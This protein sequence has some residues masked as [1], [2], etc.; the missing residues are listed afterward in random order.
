[1]TAS[2]RIFQIYYNE[3]TKAAID[4]AFEPLDNSRNERPDW[5]EY[6]PIRSYLDQHAL[7]DDTY[8]GFFSPKF[9]SKTA[10]S[11][12]DVKTFVANAGGA[13][14]VT[15]S[16]FPEQACFYRNVFEQGEIAHPGLLDAATAFFAASGISL[17][18]RQLVMDTRNTVYANYF[19]AKGTFWRRWNDLFR[20]CFEYSE[21]AASPLHDRLCR[22]TSHDKPSQMKIFLMERIP[23][24]LLA[25]MSD[26]QVRNCAPFRMPLSDAKWQPAFGNLLAMDGLKMAYLQTQE[27]IYLDCF[28]LFQ[29]STGKLLQPS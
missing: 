3:Q 24:V 18:V 12:S 28:R 17:D 4:P 27:T 20:Q 2:I 8:Y 15:F 10:M 6:W 7:D 25:T 14:V 5:F 1:M 13:D 22:A 11:G 16:P 29:E 23:S 26:L 19:V 9:S 21:N